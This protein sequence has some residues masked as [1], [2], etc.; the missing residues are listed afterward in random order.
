[1]QQLLL[2]TQLTKDQ[3]DVPEANLIVL[4]GSVEA[5]EDVLDLI[6][7]A[8]KL[9]NGCLHD[10]ESQDLI[11]SAQ[12]GLCSKAKG[13]SASAFYHARAFA[14]L[15]EETTEIYGP[16]KRVVDSIPGRLRELRGKRGTDKC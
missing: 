9:I 13:L 7:D 12:D 1:M 14:Y 11:T 5:E 4:K 2:S 3:L 8:Q 10:E 16:S 6:V 15:T